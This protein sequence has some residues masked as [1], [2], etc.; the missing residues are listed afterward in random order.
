MKGPGKLR[1]FLKRVGKPMAQVARLTG[2][3]ETRLSEFKRGARR[4]TLDQAILI[5]KATYGAVACLD[6]DDKP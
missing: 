1:E 5:D 4:P 3:S 6:W 2:I